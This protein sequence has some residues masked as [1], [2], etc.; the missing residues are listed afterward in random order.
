M[1]FS[2]M[3]IA[4]S[5]AAAAVVLPRAGFATTFGECN[6]AE[7]VFFDGNIVEAAIATPELST[8]VT[9][10]TAAGLG[11]A[12]AEAEDITV[13]APTN[14]AFAAIPED[15]LNAALADTEILSAILLYHVVPAI[16]DPRKYIPAVR[17]DT[18]LDQPVFI[19]RKDAEQ[20]VNN[21][22]VSCNAVRTS[23]GIVWLI[24]SVLMPQF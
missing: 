6:S 19:H 9:A 22:A 1:K 8:L 15:V 7:P 16:N 13:Y 17:V 21:A 14:D 2:H 18:L 20:R 12:L 4:I 3:L 5:L 24:D 10:V 23:N 11:D